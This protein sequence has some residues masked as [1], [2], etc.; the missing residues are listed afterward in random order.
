MKCS[1]L[2][3]IFLVTSVAPFAQFDGARISGWVT[4]TTGAVIVGAECQI[5][6]NETNVSTATTT[7][8]DGLYV[9]S[10]LRSAAT[11]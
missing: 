6:N 5:T 11:G 8:K 3:V 10:D 9:I 7:N 4:D 2:V 1:V